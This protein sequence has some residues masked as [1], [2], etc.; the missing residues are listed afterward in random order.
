MSGGRVK[1]RW[2]FVACACL[3]T[4]CSTQ[5]VRCDRHLT[6]INVPQRPVAGALAPRAKSNDASSQSGGAVQ[7]H[8]ARPATAPAQSDRNGR[9]V[10]SSGADG[11]GSP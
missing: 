2:V 11:E 10:S 7:P 9:A 1:M 6:P 4:A 3:L 5:A 8:G